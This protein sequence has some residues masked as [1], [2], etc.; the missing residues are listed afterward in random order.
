MKEKLDRHVISELIS[1]T[2]RGKRSFKLGGIIPGKHN[3]SSTLKKLGDELVSL[4]SEWWLS[5]RMLD[6]FESQKKDKSIILLNKLV[7]YIFK[8]FAT[9]E[10]E[11]GP[12]YRE[13][14]ANCG[15]EGHEDS[16]L[17]AYQAVQHLS[18]YVDRDVNTLVPLIG[19]HRVDVCWIRSLGSLSSRNNP[20]HSGVQIGMSRQ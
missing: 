9:H 19:N 15:I 11:C 17:A 13:V 2:T 14:I 3:W 8:I 12:F 18:K 16:V 7:Q 6:N 20:Q 5:L 10:N 4:P 1:Q